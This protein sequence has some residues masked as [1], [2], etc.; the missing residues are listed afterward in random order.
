[1]SHDMVPSVELQSIS[2]KTEK[3][4]LDPLEPALDELRKLSKDLM[5]IRLHMD[6]H[7]QGNDSSKEWLMIGIVIDRLLFATYILFISLSF[8]AIIRIWIWN[9]SFHHD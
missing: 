9:N 2:N 6:K 5:A 4:P 7:F 1:M 3:A 8:I